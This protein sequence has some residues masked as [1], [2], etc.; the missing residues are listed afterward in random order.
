MSVLLQLDLGTR[1]DSRAFELFRSK[2]WVYCMITVHNVIHNNRVLRTKKCSSLYSDWLRAGRSWFGGSI[3]GG[4]WEF[5]LLHR[6]QTGS[7][8]HP[9]SY[10]MGI[11]VK[12]TGA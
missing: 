5:S 11:G 4:G 6:L 2:T 8:A 1:P 9:A 7:G 3:P 10:P 12:A